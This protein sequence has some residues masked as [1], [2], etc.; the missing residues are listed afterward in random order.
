MLTDNVIALSFLMTD[1]RTS[2]TGLQQSYVNWF[3]RH[4]QV[5]VQ[6]PLHFI[7]SFPKQ[8]ATTAESHCKPWYLH[9]D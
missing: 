6:P 2:Q 5:S 3:R 4:P 9:Y 7:Y 1:A 8:L